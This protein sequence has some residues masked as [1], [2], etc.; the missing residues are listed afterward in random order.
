MNKEI[1][2]LAVLLGLIGAAIY[3]LS[4]TNLALTV[5]SLIGF[6]VVAALLAMAAFEY[7]ISWKSLIGR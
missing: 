7:R 4:R 6:G 2:L 1:T 3:L 5:E